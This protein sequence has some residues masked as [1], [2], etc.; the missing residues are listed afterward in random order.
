[1]KT[2]KTKFYLIGSL[3]MVFAF[4]TACSKDN[5]LNP[6]GNCGSGSWSQ[7]VQSELTSLSDAATLYTNDPTVANCENYKN[8]VG[9]YLDALEGIRTCVLGASKKAFDQAIDEAKEDLDETD[10][11]G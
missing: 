7:Q 4:S 8:A 1:M 6:I 9:D 3:V 11:N 5:P 10:C 2:I